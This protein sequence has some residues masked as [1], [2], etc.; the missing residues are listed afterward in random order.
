MAKAMWLAAEISA[1]V[2]KYLQGLNIS[3]CPP[4][5]LMQTL[6]QGKAAQPFARQLLLVL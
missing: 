5:C 1:L 6:R 4:L 3:D 2:R